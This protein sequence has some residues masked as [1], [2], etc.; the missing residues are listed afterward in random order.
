M[1]KKKQGK[2]ATRGEARKNEAQAKQPSRAS[3][4]RDYIV[5]VRT[6]TGQ[7][8][9]ARQIIDH[10]RE[11]GRPILSPQ[12]YQ[13][14]RRFR[15]NNPASGKKRSKG[16][17]VSAASYDVLRRVKKLADSLGGLD[18]LEEAVRV[19]KELSQ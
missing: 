18:R 17:S 16:S 14:L 1:S 15:Q 13:E 4:I 3:M 9:P 6:Q 2:S 8:P 12:A 7:I 19:I 11:I 10:M 5:E